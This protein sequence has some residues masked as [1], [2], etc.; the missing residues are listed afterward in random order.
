MTDR[1]LNLVVGRHRALHVVHRESLTTVRLSA[2]RGKK[3]GRRFFYLLPMAP[4]RSRSFPKKAWTTYNRCGTV[5]PN[6]CPRSGALRNRIHFSEEEVNMADTAT[7]SRPK[8][9][10]ETRGQIVIE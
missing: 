4:G 2:C 1:S 8:T 5:H 10:V 6:S 9:E 7:V 3:G